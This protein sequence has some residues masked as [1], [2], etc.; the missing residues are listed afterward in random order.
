MRRPQLIALVLLFCGAGTLKAQTVTVVFE[1][2]P[3]RKV[4]SSFAETRATDLKPD[5]AFRYQVRIVEREG[6]YYW[7]TRGMKELRRSE[8]GAYTTYHAI[9][10]SG[11]IR[12]AIAMLLDL[13]DRLPPE[14]RQNEIGYTEHLLQQFTSIT[15]FGNRLGAPK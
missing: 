10:G 1:G 13:R 15:Y 4:E 9:D 11:Y 3:L 8:S 12:V 2:E 6:R 7:Q 5:E 14:Q